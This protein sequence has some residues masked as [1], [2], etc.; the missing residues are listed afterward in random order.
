[1]GQIL[2]LLGSHKATLARL[3]GASLVLNLFGLA[4]PRFTQAVLDRV[5]PERD[6]DLLTRLVLILTTVTALQ[7]LLTVWRRLTLVRLS[8]KLDRILLGDLLAHLLTLPMGF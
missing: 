4:P 7:I 1:M 8:L 3:L 5:L 6:L 2:T